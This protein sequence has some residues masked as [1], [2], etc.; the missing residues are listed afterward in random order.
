LTIA[1]HPDVGKIGGSVRLHDLMVGQPVLISRAEPS[2]SA[3]DPDF[4]G[5][6]SDRNLSRNPFRIAPLEG[7]AVRLDA[8]GCP[9]RIAV[10]GSPLKGAIDLP[11]EAIRQGVVIELASRIV[12]LLHEGHPSFDIS[13]NTS[14]TEEIVRTELIGESEAMQKLRGDIRRVADL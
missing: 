7:G 6:L 11:T 13:G 4:R 10:E 2:F 8:S 5:P 12:L 9:T 3:D 14:A 1:Y